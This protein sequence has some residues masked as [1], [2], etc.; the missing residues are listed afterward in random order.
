M[1]GALNVH[2]TVTDHD[3]TVHERVQTIVRQNVA[4]LRRRNSTG[5]AVIQ[6][7]GV[8]SVTGDP[9]NKQLRVVTFD[10]GTEWRVVRSKRP[11]C[12]G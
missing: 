3:G 7:A 1:A 6:K 2:G 10:D 12:G 8:V 5:G 9:S 11:C 4:T